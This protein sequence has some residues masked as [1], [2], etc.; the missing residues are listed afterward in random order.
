MSWIWLYE[1]ETFGVEVDP[2]TGTITWVA[3]VGNLCGDDEGF[4]RQ[5]PAVF[6]KYGPPPRVGPLPDDVVIG[7]RRALGEASRRLSLEGD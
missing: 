7:L 5:T 3:S 6:E 4:A 2:E 1:A